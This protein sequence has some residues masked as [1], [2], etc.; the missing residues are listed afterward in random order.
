[1]TLP[2]LI[3]AALAG[4]QPV[5][6]ATPP[7]VASSQRLGRP[8]MSPM[9]EPV[10]GRTADE[11]GLVAWFQQADS[12]HDGSITVDEMQADAGRFFQTLDT[13]HDG[14]IDPDEIAHYEQ[15]IAPQVHAR[16]LQMGERIVPAGVAAG[17]RGG[18][19]GGGEAGRRGGGGRRG[20]A[21]GGG[22]GFAG[23]FGGDDEAGAGRFGLLQIPEPVSSA[24]A[25]FNRGVSTE[26]FRH[27][28]TQR[29]Q[30][31]DA[32]HTGKLTLPELQ[33]IHEAAESAARRSRSKLP[34]EGEPLDANS[35]T[36]P[37]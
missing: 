24:D 25:D 22:G 30:L 23:G 2:L 7:A 6:S 21:R 32:D 11:D 18:G 1:M 17:P 3:I 36:Q 19:G 12:N 28:A 9:G 10:F 31:L 14:E 34:D 4:A 15:V 29:F 16:A 20:G 26:E 35:Y 33:G 8:F 13:N 27:A 37:Q 5:Q